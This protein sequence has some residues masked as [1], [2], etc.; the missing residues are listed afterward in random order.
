MI[1]AVRLR[2]SASDKGKNLEASGQTFG[3]VLKETMLH[4]GPTFIKGL[5]NTHM[6][7]KYQT[8]YQSL[9]IIY[10]HTLL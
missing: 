3:I 10:K 6:I 8:I 7:L 5:A 9:Y 2:T 4:L 1:A